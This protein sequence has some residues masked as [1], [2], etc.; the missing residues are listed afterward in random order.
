MLGPPAFVRAQVLQRTEPLLWPAPP[1]GR[2]ARRV[3]WR[4]TLPGD[5]SQS[6]AGKKIPRGSADGVVPM[7]WQVS[8]PGPTR[9]GPQLAPVSPLVDSKPIRLVVAYRLARTYSNSRMRRNTRCT[10]LRRCCAHQ[11]PP[12]R[13]GRPPRHGRP[14]HAQSL[15]RKRVRRRTLTAAV[16]HRGPAWS[17][18]AKLP[19]GEAHGLRFLVLPGRTERPARARGP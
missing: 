14:L 17:R 9:S 15:V 2:V 16:R 19:F 1:K 5:P 11:P 18:A 12:V 3:E 13:G 6:W 8:R 10:V 4:M 7:A